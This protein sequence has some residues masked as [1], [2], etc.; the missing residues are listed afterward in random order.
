MSGAGL[1]MESDL[2][3][4]AKQKLGLTYQEPFYI[5]EVDHQSAPSS[6]L[7]LCD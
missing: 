4:L 6:A 1:Q 5:I 2:S 3:P 7:A